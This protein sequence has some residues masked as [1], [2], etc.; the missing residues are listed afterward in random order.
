MN[1]P[2]P[3]PT[4]VGQS[5]PEAGRAGDVG[6]GAFGQLQL[7]WVGHDGFLQKPW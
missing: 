5:V 6:A 4:I 1:S 2:K 3:A 7:L